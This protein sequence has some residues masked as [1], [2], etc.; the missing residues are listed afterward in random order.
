MS[1]K[2]ENKKTKKENKTMNENTMVINGEEWVKK[3]SIPKNEGCVMAAKV[4]SLPYKMVRTYSA[5]V[6]AGYV[7]SLDGQHAVLRNARR[8]WYWDGAAS[9]SELAMRGTSKPENCKF[10]CAVDRVELLNVIELIDI[11]DLAAKSI[12]E[13][14]EWT[15]H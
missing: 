2:K 8:I 10:P 5:G 13:V 14:K 11:T 3:S 9:L 6:F 12:A 7:E 15:K 4:D 1:T